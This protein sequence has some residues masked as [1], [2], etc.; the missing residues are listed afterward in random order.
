MMGTKKNKKKG[1]GQAASL[2]KAFKKA[3]LH[4][5]PAEQA[6]ID[7]PPPVAEAISL[8]R[9]YAADIENFRMPHAPVTPKELKAARPHI[10]SLDGKPLIWAYIGTDDPTRGDS[11][12]ANGLAQEVARLMGGR[13]VYVDSAMLK[14]NFPH[15]SEIRDAL[16]KFVKRE[17]MADIVIGTNSYDVIG[18]HQSR[19]T[20]I[21][22]KINESVDSESRRRTN[23]VP[24]DLTPDILA[25][26]GVEFLEKYPGIKRPLY[27]VMLSSFYNKDAQTAMQSL[28]KVLKFE[29]GATVFFCPS[30][31][32][33]DPDYQT[34]VQKLNEE[35]TFLNI[36]R[37]IKIISP[38]FSD[39]RAGYNPYRGLISQAD[40]MLVIGD[41]Y[42]IISESICT[43][44]P[45]YMVDASN[46]Y[47]KLINAGYVRNFATEG[48]NKLSVTILPPA[49]ITT[50][51]AGKL[52]D[53]FD[54]LARLRTIGAQEQKNNR[55]HRDASALPH[56]KI[57]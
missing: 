38:S 26:A 11:R 41:S 45:V 27:G 54:R 21:V 39:M 1:K 31:R 10:N 18:I 36:E 23:L 7:A 16:R 35:I 56:R 48:Q 42:S 29:E 53:E 25:A 57:A 22:K 24:H 49:S 12:G 47:Q 9:A 5:A 37:R 52:I 32:T 46:D 33:Y 17:G 34:L 19:P 44:R 3:T 28:A 14:K 6:V 50:E 15:T 40:H 20:M 51:V 13:A 30:R 4:H 43:G 2:L 55:R 8:S